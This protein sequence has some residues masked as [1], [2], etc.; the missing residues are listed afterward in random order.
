MRAWERSG[1]LSALGAGVPAGTIPARDAWVFA[2]PSKAPPSRAP[3]EGVESVAGPERAAAPA[4]IPGVRAS[5]PRLLRLPQF[6]PRMRA[7]A[8]SLIVAMA[9]G[10]VWYVSTTHTNS[11]YRTQ[12][13]ALATVPLSDPSNVPLTTHT[14]LPVNFNPPL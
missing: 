1:R 5:S 11:S 3:Q 8:A 7:V 13:G 4:N 10:T 6:S 12:I 9:A 14:P 2:P